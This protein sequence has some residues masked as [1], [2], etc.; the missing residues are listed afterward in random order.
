[1]HQHLWHMPY[2]FQQKGYNYI[3]KHQLSRVLWIVIT[4]LSHEY[5]KKYK[6]GNTFIFLIHININEGLQVYHHT[7]CIKMICHKVIITF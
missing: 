5:G 6:L 2:F 3:F 1:M 7:I 4:Y